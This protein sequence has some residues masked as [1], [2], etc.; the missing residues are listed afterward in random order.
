MKYAAT[1]VLTLVVF[2]VVCLLGFVSANS[3]WARDCAKLGS[4]VLDGVVY[5]CKPRSDAIPDAIPRA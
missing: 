5:D 1:A 2:W 3:E 4:H